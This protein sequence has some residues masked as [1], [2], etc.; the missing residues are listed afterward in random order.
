[1]IHGLKSI[2][3]AAQTNRTETK[4][5]VPA[6]MRLAMLP[7]CADISASARSLFL[8]SLRLIAKICCFSFGLLCALFC[9]LVFL[10][11]L[12]WCVFFVVCG[13]FVCCVF[14]CLSTIMGGIKI[15][16]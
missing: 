11:G 4:Q 16:F 10:W 7:A 3:L 6:P 1:M 5:H 9:C 2:V 14:G 8:F 13:G 15:Q 12:F